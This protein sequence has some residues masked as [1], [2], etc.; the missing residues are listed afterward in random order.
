LVRSDY[1]SVGLD[2]GGDF[3]VAPLSFVR[4]FGGVFSIRRRVL[5]SV[6][7]SFS[8]SLGVFAMTDEHSVTNEH[9]LGIGHIAVA[10]A[11]LEAILMYTIGSLLEI[12][13]ERTMVTFWHMGYNDRRDR[14]NSLAQLTLT[15][16]EE[17]QK[18]F[19]CL[20][21]R[22]NAGYRIRN[23]AV[24]S[25]WAK[26][27]KPDAITPHMMTARSGKI[28]IS[29]INQPEEHFT[30][31]RFV[32]EA[33]KIQRVGQDFRL[34]AIRHLGFQTTMQDETDP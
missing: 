25:V 13:D 26:S 20:I 33:Q 15:L 31:Q 11:S 27:D 8:G 32:E 12:G 34:F 28:K 7:V 9:R 16:D 3:R 17:T 6:G 14:L 22:M 30:P 24:H 19:D 4:G 18:E 23:V 21:T 10:W 5:S 2:G 1:L 29:G